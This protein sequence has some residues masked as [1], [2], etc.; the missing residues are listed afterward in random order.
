MTWDGKYL[1]F[2]TFM[3]KMKSG[4]DEFEKRNR[5]AT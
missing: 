5:K 2:F 4:S 3:F 1:I